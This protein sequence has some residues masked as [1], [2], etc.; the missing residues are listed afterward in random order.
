[1]AL[2]GPLFHEFAQPLIEPCLMTG[3]SGRGKLLS[4][5]LGPLH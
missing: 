2:C 1:M 5:I 3:S 4:E